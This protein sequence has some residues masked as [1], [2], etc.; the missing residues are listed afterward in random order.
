V[1]IYQTKAQTHLPISNKHY[2]HRLCE[3]LG[4]GLLDDHRLHYFAI[5]MLPKP[6]VT[7][8]L[9]ARD[10]PLNLRH[11]LEIVEM[12]VIVISVVEEAQPSGVRMVA[13]SATRRSVSLSAH[14]RFSIVIDELSSTH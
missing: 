6:R 5:K 8:K 12:S 14:M 3:R 7:V 2:N 1:N 11:R 10:S 9:N 4:R 13:N